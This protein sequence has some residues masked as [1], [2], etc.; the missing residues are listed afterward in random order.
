M[1]KLLLILLLSFSLIAESAPNAIKMG[2]NFVTVS[3]TVVFN[4]TMQAG[5]TFTLSAQAMDGGGRAPGDPFTIR[6]VFYNSSNAIVNTA[7]LS[8]TLVYGNTTP[9]T[10]TTTTTNCGGSCANVAY[11]KVE[12]YGKDGGYWAGNYGPYIINPSLKFNGGSNILY[13]PEFGVYGTNGFAQG[14][15][16]SNGWQNCALYNGA[17]TCVVNNGALVNEAGGGYSSTG[18]TTSSPPGGQTTTPALCCGGS[19]AS[20]N[21]S[22]ANTA[23][24]QAF[25]NRTS[26]D[27]QVYIE[28]IGNDNE[29]TVNQSGT[30]NNYTN[31]YSTGSF[32]TVNITQSGNMSTT[33]NYVE[34]DVLGNSN[35]VTLTQ[36]STGGAK[37]IYAT[38]NDNNNNVTVLQKDGGN[39]YLNLSLSGGN[40][41]VDITQQGSANH[42]ADITLS[43]AGARSLNLN[44]QGSTQ[45]FYSIN[46]TCASSCQAIT[47][48][49]GQ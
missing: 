25:V 5:G 2:Y 36:Q 13:N 16:S 49:Q 6:M 28:Q 41:T 46:S 22:P 18:G 42:M 29:I 7:Q 43:G 23:K 12:F 30:R 4:S 26:A 37:G 3:Q 27:S 1:K 40:K 31:Y 20:F 17:Q 47:V 21:A 34:L 39:D 19:S 33:A 44:Q 15:T 38:V 10:Y 11:V 32:N 9:T 48:I 45:Q 14:W 8:N 35:T 24:A